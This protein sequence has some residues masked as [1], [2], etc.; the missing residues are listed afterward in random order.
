[1][2]QS[3]FLFHSFLT[4]SVAVAMESGRQGKS[5]CVSEQWLDVYSIMQISRLFLLI[6]LHSLEPI[7][8]HNII[9]LWSKMYLSKD[10][11]LIQAVEG[12]SITLSQQATAL[13]QNLNKK[14]K[15]SLISFESRIS[16]HKQGTGIRKIRWIVCLVFYSICIYECKN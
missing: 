1:M 15:P 13:Q 8:F 2:E 14:D 9:K 11:R 10:F 5:E 12:Q 16:T 6:N 3:R 7:T 4:F